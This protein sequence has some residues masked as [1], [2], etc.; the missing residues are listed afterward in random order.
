[1]DKKYVIDNIELMKEWDFEKNDELGVDP[2]KLT[3]GSHKKIWWKCQ[4]RHEWQAVI[5]DR[6]RGRGCP[7]CAGKKVVKGYTD[8]QTIN[9]AL[10]KEWNYEKN[11][12]LLP[13]DVMPNSNKKVWWKCSK[14]HE[15]Q[16]LIDSRNR[17]R[18]CPYCTGRKVLKGYT[19]LQTVNS[20]LAKEWNYKKNN[21]LT[22]MD[23]T[24]NS[25]IKVWW[26]C[27]KGHAWQ[28]TIGSR[29]RGNGCPICYSER[30]TSFPEYA[31][32]YYFQKYEMEVIHSYK[33]KGYEL[34]VYIPSK[35][36]LL[37]TMDIIGIKTEQ[38][39]I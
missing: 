27:K 13:M 15:W 16:A 30:N 14:G 21:G 37:S 4:K 36:S 17:G 38:K 9:P 10:A 19:D 31:L 20:E 22:P 33:G 6:N 28:A 7:Y 18:G 32:V 25:D 26:T 34:D 12:E 24:P 29:H 39:K 8:L 5:A 23:V 11:N 1:M 3:C 2:E 35:K